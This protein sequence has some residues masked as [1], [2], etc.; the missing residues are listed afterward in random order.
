MSPLQ[1]DGTS[2]R[3]PAAPAAQ[4]KWYFDRATEDERG[5]RTTEAEC[6][7][8]TAAEWARSAAVAELEA[9]ALSRFAVIK[10]HQGHPEAAKRAGLQS[11]AAARTAPDRA[12]EAQTLNV[13]AG[14][15]LERGELDDARKLF[16]DALMLA[17]HREDLRAKIEQNLGIVANVQ[18]DWGL[19]ESHY[20]R[21]LEIY[22]RLGDWRGE[23]MACHNLGMM[24][25]DHR[26]F[27]R[28]ERYFSE[29]MALSR[30]LRDRRLEA[31]C[32][33]NRGEI[34]VERQAYAHAEH[35][36]E[37]ARAIF[38][39]LESVVEEADCR[40]VLGSI[41][42]Q[43]GRPEQAIA[44]LTAAIHLAIDADTPLT[45]AE[46]WRELGYL[47]ASQ[48]R[49]EEAYQALEEAVALF[50]RLG[51]RHEVTEVSRRLSD[52]V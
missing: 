12:T 13:L 43:T 3:R 10:H 31:L 47:R 26:D 30:L 29:A 27:V 7:Y 22:R 46:A 11:L 1:P 33:L 9:E 38:L 15:S 42:A 50:D 39:T 37:D 51:A 45:E 8:L 32:L 25:A 21:A 35:D 5:G 36:V 17:A 14:L 18:G 28:A 2:E 48:G 23:A 6:G 44:H 49:I 24:S 34:L 40:R 20:R 19:A 16:E 41:T 4:A 52:L